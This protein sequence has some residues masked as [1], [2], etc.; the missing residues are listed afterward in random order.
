[1]SHKMVLVRGGIVTKF[2][3]NSLIQNDNTVFLLFLS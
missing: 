3:N 2:D 1:M